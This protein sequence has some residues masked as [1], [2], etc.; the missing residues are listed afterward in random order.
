[1]LTICQRIVTNVVHWRVSKDEEKCH[2]TRNDVF[3]VSFEEN[4]HAGSPS[5]VAAEHTD[6]A[7]QEHSSAWKSRHNQGDGCSVDESPG[8]VSHVDNLLGIGIV[9]AEHT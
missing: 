4:P 9:D 8:R 3:G 7:N 6:G 1:M 5:C 2:S